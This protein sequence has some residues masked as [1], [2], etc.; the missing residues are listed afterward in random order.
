MIYMLVINKSLPIMD[1]DMLEVFKSQ[2]IMESYDD[3]SRELALLF[4]NYLD[5]VFRVDKKTEKEVQKKIGP[6][7]IPVVNINTMD[8]PDFQKLDFTA[9][10][11]VE[12]YQ[13]KKSDEI[14]LQDIC[15]KQFKNVRSLLDRIAASIK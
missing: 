10:S 1:N 8:T 13:M 14:I 11:T 12:N 9:I 15:Y 7:V 4:C 5:E 2:I 3:R 6:E